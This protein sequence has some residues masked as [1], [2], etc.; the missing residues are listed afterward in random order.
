MYQLKC[1]GL[2]Y[3]EEKK[4]KEKKILLKP[5]DKGECMS[6]ADGLINVPSVSAVPSPCYTLHFVTV[7][8]SD[9]ATFVEPSAEGG[10]KRTR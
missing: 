2:S 1:Y 4:R 8:L 10:Q 7:M 9:V 6:D 3:G 5:T